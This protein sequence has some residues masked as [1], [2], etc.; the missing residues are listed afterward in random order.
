MIEQLLARAEAD[1]E[2]A[3][4]RREIAAALAADW[5]Y[6]APLL[7]GATEP[8]QR[9]PAV[10]GPPVLAE[11]AAPAGEPLGCRRCGGPIPPRASGGGG[12]PKVFCSQRCGHAWHAKQAMQRKRA[13][14]KVEA[15]RTSTEIE[16]GAE[17]LPDVRPEERPLRSGKYEDGWLQEQLKLPALPWEAREEAH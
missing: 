4:R 6:W 16:L 8:V 14:A 11:P 10:A 15:R 1:L 12:R 13:A 7:N 9:R 2:V 17:P 5:A 3:T